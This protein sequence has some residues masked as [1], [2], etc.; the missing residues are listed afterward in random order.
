MK[1]I[2]PFTAEEYF[3]QRFGK[4]DADFF[5]YWTSKNIIEF[6][7]AYHREKMKQEGAR[8]EI[9][10]ETSRF[11]GKKGER[12]ERNRILGIIEELENEIAEDDSYGLSDLSAVI[13]IKQKIKGE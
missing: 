6:A 7:E 13:M 4:P 3:Q 2:K 10:L 11:W 5:E 8:V 9:S 12:H 1:E